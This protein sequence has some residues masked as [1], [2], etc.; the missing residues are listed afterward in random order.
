MYSRIRQS[1]TI[2]LQR[3]RDGEVVRIKKHYLR[4]FL[5]DWRQSLCEAVAPTNDKKYDDNEEKTLSSLL[6]L[7]RKPRSQSEPL[8]IT[9]STHKTLDIAADPSDRPRKVKRRCSYDD[10]DMNKKTNPLSKRHKK[11]RYNNLLGNR[12]NWREKCRNARTPNDKSLPSLE[13]AAIMFGFKM[14]ALQAVE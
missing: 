14:A 7:K 1:F 3:M 12:E 13:E 9:P 8:S 6:L 10:K 5:S 4:L 2:Q 11:A